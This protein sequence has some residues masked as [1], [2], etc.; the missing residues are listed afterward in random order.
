M[1]R[2]LRWGVLSTALINEKV[3]AGAARSEVVD[4]VAVAS[5]DR[6][7]AEAFAQRW[8]IPT[9]HGS[10]DDLLADETVEAVYIP[11]PNGLHH[12]WTM[13]ALAAGKHVLCEKPYS[14]N[15]VQVEEAF[16]AAKA[17]GL[18][19]SEAFMYRYNPQI[20]RLVELVVAERVI[21]DVRLVV[22]SFS[23]PT[24]ASGDVRLDPDLEG[25]ALLDVGCYCV[26]AARLL[27]GEPLSVTAQQLVGPTGV[28]VSFV[29]T[30]HH[31][32]GV[33][34]HFDAALHLPDRSHLEVVGTLGTITVRDPWH[35]FAPGL[36]VTPVTTSDTPTPTSYAV[37]VPVASSYQLELEELGKAVRGEDNVM[38]GRADALG[39]S[40]AIEA[41]ETAARNG[42]TVAVSGNA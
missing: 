40:A 39:Q 21:G 22:G 12:E 34:S 24:A 1:T 7:R 14:R 15:P 26:S 25:G 41:L 4:V 31:A 30:M 11:L 2:A 32:D 42:T 29:A 8:D 5:R 19:L 16:A 3:L 20:R 23:W 28:D 13:R 9:A 18:V 33:L 6:A 17:R 36:T 10:Y 27:A 35:C 37:E 38:L